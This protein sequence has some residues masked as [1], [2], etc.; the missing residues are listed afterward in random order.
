MTGSGETGKSLEEQTCFTINSP[1]RPQQN[2]ATSAKINKTPAP[3]FDNTSSPWSEFGIDCE[4]K[5]LSIFVFHSMTISLLH[6]FFSSVVEYVSVAKV[7]S[8]SWPRSVVEC[9]YCIH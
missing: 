7:D 3:H 1:T 4:Y 2:S 8:V 9:I 5:I 6:C